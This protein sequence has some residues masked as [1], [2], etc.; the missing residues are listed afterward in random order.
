VDSASGKVKMQSSNVDDVT[1]ELATLED[2]LHRTEKQRRHCNESTERLKQKFSAAE[3]KLERLSV[4][5]HGL[6][7]YAVVLNTLFCCYSCLNL[8]FVDFIGKTQI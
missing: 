2:T 5:R 6:L 1:N 7:V 4:E 3:A 8:A